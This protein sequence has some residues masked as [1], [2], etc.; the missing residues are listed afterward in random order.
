MKLQP[1]PPLN[2]LVAFEAAARHLSFTLAARELNVTQGAISRQIRVLEDYLGTPLFVR[3]TRE[4]NLTTTGSQYYESVRATLQQI[5]HATA[6]VRHWRG[7]QQVTV[8]TTTAM[9]SLWLLP[10][11]SE[12]Q[13]QNEE[14]D[15]RIITNDKVEDFSRLDCDLALYYCSTPP[16][17]M[18]VTPLFSG[19][20]FPVCSP[21]FLAQHPQI[22]DLDQLGSCTWLWLEDPRRDWIGWKEWFERLGH[23]AP[24]PRRRID[25][26]SYS[27]LIQSALAGQGIALA[28]SSLL[29]NYLQTGELVRPTQATLMTDAQFFLIEPQGRAPNRQSVSRFREW[30]MAHLAETVNA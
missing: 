21:S 11:V 7:A 20:I 30:L 26:N 24:E 3:S 10:L 23:V 13:R 5:V 8:I 1:L 15:L 18:K 17:N 2:S 9:A 29:G 4:I 22:S 28:W 12:F 25:I 27:M 19:E 14:I 6:G 16:Q